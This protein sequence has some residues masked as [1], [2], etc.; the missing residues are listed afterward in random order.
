MIRKVERERIALVRL[1]NN[2]YH[3]N[4]NDN[5]KKI[6]KVTIFVWED[7]IGINKSKGDLRRKQELRWSDNSRRLLSWVK[8]KLVKKI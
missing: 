5:R 4:K 1:R 7:V 6:R 2:G 3:F 8:C